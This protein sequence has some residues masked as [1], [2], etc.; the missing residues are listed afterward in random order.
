MVLTCDAV[1]SENWLQ[2]NSFVIRSNPSF[3][4]L[5]LLLSLKHRV[6]DEH[7]RRSFASSIVVVYGGLIDY[8]IVTPCTHILWRRLGRL[9]SQFFLSRTYIHIIYYPYIRSSNTRDSV[10]TSVVCYSKSRDRLAFTKRT[11]I[12]DPYKRPDKDWCFRQR[13][14]EQPWQE[15]TWDDRWHETWKTSCLSKTWR[16]KALHLQLWC[17]VATFTHVV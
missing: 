13:Q 16:K 12:T 14:V 17:A 10:I 1:T 2:T 15:S 9:S 7:S 6:I 4:F 8:G 3:L 11:S 5:T